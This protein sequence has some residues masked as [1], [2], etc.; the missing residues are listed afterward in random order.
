[1]LRQ[2]LIPVVVVAAWT[3]GTADAQPVRLQLDAVGEARI[4]G[5]DAGNVTPVGPSQHAVPDLLGYQIGRWEPTSRI[6]DLFSGDWSITG[7]F[8]RVDLGFIGHVNPPGPLAQQNDLFSP[9]LYGP[10]PAFGFVEFDVDHNVTTGGEVAYPQLRYLANVA[11]F[12]GKPVTSRYA[13]RVV[14]YPG[15]IDNNMLTPPFFERSGEEFHLALFG[16][17]IDETF[18]LVGDT[19]GQFE[20]GEK[21]IVR[22]RLFHRAHGFERFSFTASDGV[23]EPVVDLLYDS[24]TALNI[25]FVSLVF[26]M[27]NAD[28][29]SLTNAPVE[30]NDAIATNQS[31]IEEAIA[32]LV[33]SAN[34]IP[35]GSPLT[36]DPAY[37]LIR[38]WSNQNPQNS[39]NPAQWDVTA[40]VGMSYE[41]QAGPGELYAP[42]DVLDDP[43]EGDFNG[44]GRVD[45]EDS[46]LLETFILVEEEQAI[47]DADGQ[48]NGEVVLS[49]FGPIF[50]VF[51]LDYDGVVGS[52]DSDAVIPMGDLDFDC[53]VDLD[54]VAIFVTLLVSPQS[55]SSLDIADLTP[56]ADFR[57]DGVIDGGD[58]RG[59]TSRFLLE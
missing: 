7:G 21:W 6:D 48:T 9:Y 28:A 29:A 20:P 52:L 40:I 31:S 12:G 55:F 22:G 50:S 45:C 14:L 41:F 44:D 3:T 24:S 32:E 35:M 27:T 58:I 2:L 47:W 49:G 56:R 54:D 26:P 42:T 43:I 25:T 33:N 23:Y 17:K 37:S 59:F 38:N 46:Q 34:G 30:P 57:Q 39:L 51:D 19:D 1:M 13:D 16:D 15:D 18:V 11:R 10:S 4:R 53:D 8:L 5:I 36:N